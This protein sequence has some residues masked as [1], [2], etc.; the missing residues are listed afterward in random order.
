ME[1]PAMSGE[2]HKLGVVT[3]LAWFFKNKARSEKLPGTREV[4]YD[5]SQN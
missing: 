5:L 1:M 2:L 4:A 3:S